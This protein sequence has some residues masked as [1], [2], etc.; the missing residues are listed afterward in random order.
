MA[1]GAAVLGIRLQVHAG[2]V[3]TALAGRAA[4][5]AGAAVVDIG[6]QIDAGGVAGL[7]RRIAHDFA[8]ALEADLVGL[9]ETSTGTAVE[10]VLLQIHTGSATTTLAGGADMVTG[11]AVCVI[12]RGVG[13]DRIA[14][15]PLPLPCIRALV[16]ASSAVIWVSSGLNALD[17]AAVVDVPIRGH[18]ERAARAP[19]ADLARRA[20]DG[21]VAIGAGRATGFGPEALLN[22]A[23]VV[24]VCLAGAQDERVLLL[25]EMEIVIYA[26]LHL[27]LKTL[28][29]LIDAVIRHRDVTRGR[30]LT[31]GSVREHRLFQPHRGEH[32]GHQAAAQPA[33]RLPPR[34]AIRHVLRQRI[35]VQ[36]LAPVG[37]GQPLRQ[38]ARRLPQGG[39]RRPHRHRQT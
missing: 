31:V 4:M 21:V 20:A 28:V 14:A 35:K 38:P 30:R 19:A 15:V 8:P 13:T 11:A 26:L 18:A 24:A 22:R 1:A 16:T 29:G 32:G 7:Q 23:L 5:L 2:G 3:A 17:S 25:L 9:A 6:L 37:P 10:V 33:Q 27:A 36:P 39:V 12:S 34:Q